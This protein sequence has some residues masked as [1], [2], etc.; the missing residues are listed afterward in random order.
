MLLALPHFIQA[1]PLVSAI[2]IAGY[3]YGYLAH[4][5]RLTLPWVLLLAVLLLVPD[6]LF[7]VAIFNA[8]VLCFLLSSVVAG[9]IGFANTMTGSLAGQTAALHKRFTTWGRV[10]FGIAWAI[11]NGGLLF[12]L[13]LTLMLW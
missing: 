1:L 8:S 7:L 6:A 13:A 3:L 11:A 10:K 12:L 2:I 5:K 9:L 4:A